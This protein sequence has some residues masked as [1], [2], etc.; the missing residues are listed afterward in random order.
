MW[1]EYSEGVFKD[2]DNQIVTLGFLKIKPYIIFVQWD[3]F[4]DILVI[5]FKNKIL[6]ISHSY[7]KFDDF[8]VIYHCFL[9]FTLIV[10]YRE[11]SC[12]LTSLLA[13]KS[14]LAFLRQS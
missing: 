7:V 9:I 13:F 5:S 4:L 14:F 8:K 11:G 12:I 10:Q 2:G 1:I 6:A 3:C